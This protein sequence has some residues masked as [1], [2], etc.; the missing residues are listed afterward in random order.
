MD[1][2]KIGIIG[3]TGVYDPKLLKDAEQVEVETPY[4][5]PSDKVTVGTLEGREVAFLPRH[6]G[7]HSI[8]P[9]KV[10][11]RANI[12]A[13]KELGCTRIF[14]TCATGSLKKELKPGDMVIVD[15]FIDLSKDVHTF[16]DEGKFYHVPMAEPFC[17]ELRELLLN[18]AKG[19]N[20]PVH[21]KGTYMRIEGPQFS[22]IAASN[23]NRQFADLIGMTGVP[24][25]ILSREQGI[26]FAIIATITDYDSWIGKHTEFAEMKKVMAKNMQNTRDVLMEAVLKVPEKRGCSCK[27]ALKGAK[28]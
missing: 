11:W 22:T 8:P 24:E 14:A 15:Q 26:C 7:S 10:N 21:G 27:D 12:W 28:A 3:G 25:A 9:H 2:A 19:R 23:M 13:L 4:G 18:I 16:Y 5:K 1:K 6:G 17:P 20:I